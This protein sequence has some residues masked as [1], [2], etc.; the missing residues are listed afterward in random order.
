[1]TK[2]QLKVISYINEHSGEAD[3]VIMSQHFDWSLW[4]IYDLIESLNSLQC[5]YTQ[6]KE[7]EIPTQDGSK[8][9]VF[10]IAH[11]GIIFLKR[12]TND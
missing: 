10:S 8:K 4:K 1:M 5:I 12:E 7:R 3:C 9:R 6:W 11:N 2:N